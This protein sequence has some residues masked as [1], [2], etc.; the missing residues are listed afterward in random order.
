MRRAFSKTD[1]EES[2]RVAQSVARIDALAALMDAAFVIP[3]T[4]VKMGLDGLVGLVPVVGDI[5]ASVISSYIVWEAR[6]LGAPR[7]LIARMLIN[8]AIDTAVGSVPII[9]DAFDVMF[10]ANVMNMALLK[11]H[12]ERE[13]KLRASPIIDVV[14]VRA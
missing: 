10:R 2:A 7:W 13:G 12:L 3:G 1:P 14:P 8:V 9:G 11:R 4:N 6:Q 5:V